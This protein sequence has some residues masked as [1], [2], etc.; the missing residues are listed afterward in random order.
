ML[1]TQQTLTLCLTFILGSTAALLNAPYLLLVIILPLLYFVYKNSVSVKFALLIVAVLVFSIFYAGFRTPQPDY[2][3]KIAPAEVTVKGVVEDPS[4]STL[5]YK[6]KLAFKVT[7]IKSDK[8]WKEIKSVT[9]LN[10]YDKKAKFNKIQPGDILEVKGYLKKPYGAQNPGQFDYSRYL[11]NRGIF[12]NIF[13]DWKNYKIIGKS[14]SPYRKF[15]RSLYRLKEKIMSEHAKYIKSPKLEILGGIVFGNY[16]VPAPYE[17]KQDFIKSGLMHLLAASGMNVAFIFGIWFFIALKVRLNYKFSIITG[18]VLVLAYSLLTG[19]PPSVTRA[20]LMLEFILLGKYLDRQADTVTLLAF[21]CALMVLYNPMFLTNIG[22]QLSFLVT[23][24]LLVCVPVF[25]EK[26][27]PMPEIVAGVFVVPLTAQIWAAP[28]QLFHFN[29]FSIYSVLANIVVMPF[30]ALISFL[31]FISSILSLLPK[32]GSAVCQF[33]D[34]LVEPFINLLLAVSHFFSGLP[35]AVL[36]LR[37]PNVY[38]IFLFYAALL[39]F[40]Y[41]IK[42]NIAKKRLIFAL[43]CMIFILLLAFFRGFFDKNLKITFLSVGEGDAIVIETPERKTILVDT[44]AKGKE[45]FSQA[46]AAIVPYLREKGLRKINGIVFTHPDD[47]HIGG[48]IDVMTSI[49]PGIIYDNGKKSHGKAYSAL[50]KYIKKNGLT[51]RHISKKEIIAQG[52]GYKITAFKIP[53][54]V[55]DNN[56]S[57]ILLAENGGFRTL[58]TGDADAH[59]LYKLRQ[60]VKPPIDVLKV[61]H[62]GGKGTV[63]D[64]LLNYLKPEYA[65]ISV[66]KNHYG[67]PA[68]E[69][70]ELL[71]QHHIKTYRTDEDCAVSVSSEEGKTKVKAFCNQI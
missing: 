16:A 64:K 71:R 56:E 54:A 48:G 32:I 60:F 12:T 24:G 41:M 21:V 13:S 28:V 47:D 62:H 40:V 27:R 61:G 29:T 37:A 18:A 9:L 58:L 31:G 34:K 66:G 30:M 55:S 25:M 53:D 39:L 20:A 59:S 36:Y 69:T 11:N 1:K 3:Y 38:E 35:N 51:L 68:K 17:V 52:S 15:S 46:K 70:L 23:F 6:A 63:N 57:V 42:E 22:F 45:N 49:K 50:Y 7:E 44:A 67:H 19:L 33:L 43:F 65:V 26:L 8:G 2:L 4:E 10:I 5:S 14:S